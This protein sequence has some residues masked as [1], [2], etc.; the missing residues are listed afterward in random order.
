MRG[1][2]GM[3]EGKSFKGG[4]A[5]DLFLP[6]TVDLARFPLTTFMRE[7]HWF[8]T[9]IDATAV[10]RIATFH[11]QRGFWISRASAEYGT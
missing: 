5:A 3:G 4:G 1:G 6:V 9:A 11:F 7:S 10:L 2:K 8:C